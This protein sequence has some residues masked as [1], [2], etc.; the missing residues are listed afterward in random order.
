MVHAERVSAESGVSLLM[1]EGLGLLSALA[2]LPFVGW[3]SGRFKHIA[4]Q[5]PGG[6][7]QVPVESWAFKGVVA[8][9]LVR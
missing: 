8:A 2:V 3:W 6:W 9:H 7:W 4:V 5:V 1:V